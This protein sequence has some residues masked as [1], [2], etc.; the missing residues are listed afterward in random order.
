MATTFK[1]LYGSHTALTITSL[2]SLTNGS[3]AGSAVVDNSS[4]LLDDALVSVTINSPTSSTSTTGSVT[5]YAY[6]DTDSTPHYTDGVSGADATQTPTNP[7]N[8]R[9]IG[10]GNVVSN[11][12]TYRLGPFPVASAFGGHMPL[13]WGIVVLNNTASTLNSSGNSADYLPVQDQGV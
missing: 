10:V 1:P 13:K 7:T 12:T 5:I 11:N 4:A 8:L 2:N 6:A 3:Y 9:P